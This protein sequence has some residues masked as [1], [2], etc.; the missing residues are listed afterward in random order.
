MPISSS[1]TIVIGVPMFKATLVIV[2]GVLQSEVDAKWHV[3]NSHEEAST[4]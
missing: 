3:V 1:T 4:F 2:V